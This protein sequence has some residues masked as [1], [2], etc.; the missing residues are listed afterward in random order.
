MRDRLFNL[1]DDVKSRALIVRVLVATTALLK[2][3]IGTAYM[4]QSFYGISRGDGGYD[5]GNNYYSRS[6]ATRCEGDECYGY[7]YYGGDH[8]GNGGYTYS[9]GHGNDGGGNQGTDVQLFCLWA[10][11]I[12]LGSVPLTFGFQAVRPPHLSTHA[13]R[14]SRPHII[15][16]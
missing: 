7:G 9:G 11:F 8:G 4:S 2:L 3:F 5:G 6:L 14:Y 1:E 12:L 13:D 15:T 16:S 10:G